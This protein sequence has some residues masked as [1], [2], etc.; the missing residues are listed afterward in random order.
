M[1]TKKTSMSLVENDDDDDIVD[2]ELGV[3]VVSGP[4]RLPMVPVV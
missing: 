3:C 4:Q 1:S 2:D